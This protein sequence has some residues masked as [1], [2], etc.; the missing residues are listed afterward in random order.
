MLVNSVLDCVHKFS[1]VHLSLLNGANS[2]LVVV[3]G[4]ICCANQENRLSQPYLM[5]RM[6]LSNCRLEG[7][8]L[9]ILALCRKFVFY[10]HSLNTM[11]QLT[12]SQNFQL[13][14]RGILGVEVHT[15]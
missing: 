8:L 1:Q 3:Y 6:Y 11:E 2:A 4:P 5:G 15:S 12:N 10:K 7:T 14:G 9:I 13:A